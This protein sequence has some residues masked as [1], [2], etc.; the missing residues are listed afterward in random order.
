[1][2]RQ[3]TFTVSLIM[4][5]AILGCKR[6]PSA[7]EDVS[8]K[9]TEA[10]TAD[11]NPAA[12]SVDVSP[13]DIMRKVADFYKGA[14]QIE[15]HEENTMQIKM[16][17]MN[18]NITTERMMAADKPGRFAIR[19]KSGMMAFDIVSDGTTLFSS[20]SQTKQYTEADA[21]ESLDELVMH[22][23]LMAMESG[24]GVFTIHLVADDPYERL[25]NGVTL[26]EYAGVEMLQGIEVHHL[27][28][29]QEELDWDIWVAASGAPLIHK[30]SV[31]LAKT[32]KAAGNQFQGQDVSMIAVSRYTDWRIDQPINE[33][34]FVF[35]PPEGAE[36]SDSLFGDFE[37]EEEPSSLL[38]MEAPALELDLLGGGHMNMADHGGTDIVMLDFWATWCGPCVQEMP[39]LAEV[40]QE[41]KDKGVVFY[42]VNQQEE[43]RDIKEFLDSQELDITVALDVD[44]VA[45]TSYEVQAYPT[46]M[47]IDKAGIIQTVHVGY[48]PNIKTVLRKELDDLLAGKDLAEEARKEL[49][50]ADAEAARPEGLTLVWS[51]QGR[52]QSVAVADTRNEIYALAQGGQCSVFNGAG[53]EQR[54]FD[55]EITPTM[56]RIANLTPAELPELLGYDAWGAAVAAIGSD[57][58]T[59][60]TE[61]SGDGI[62][63]VWAAD[64]ND[65]GHDEVIVGYNG[66]TG[67]HVFSNTGVRLWKNTTIGNVWHVTAG[68]VTGDGK[69]EIVTT[70]A[71][72]QVHLFDVNG[73]RQ[74]DLE[75]TTYASMVRVGRVAPDSTAD[76]IYVVGSGDDGEEVVALDETGNELWTL[77]LAGGDTH[78]DSMAIAPGVPWGALGLRGGNVHVVDLKEGRIIST[79]VRHGRTPQVGWISIDGGTPQLLVATGR[80]LKAYEVTPGVNHELETDNAASARVETESDREPS[81]ESKNDPTRDGSLNEAGE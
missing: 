21:P 1:M 76:S 67:L 4:L 49:E 33:E 28:F 25:M 79:A 39:D 23:L 12:P 26:S 47:L 2:Y 73:E 36:K 69:T 9:E 51:Q 50:A 35:T 31:D 5:L 34:A 30:V 72:G 6:Q 74:V 80:A 54:R 81:E 32:L 48:D 66:G 63:D 7:P 24:G 57:G 19:T 61:A 15:V 70:S 20:L 27:S 65:D 52:Y 56:L 45:A 22:P 44:S 14:G 77:S 62:D 16:Q 8:L 53:E 29:T 46:L 13:E 3:F 43:P 17:G 37:M 40:A 78:C 41:Y 58:S 11:T 60:W 68:D 59:L 38:G 42:A 18:N 71:Q 64:I 10:A 75:S 55:I